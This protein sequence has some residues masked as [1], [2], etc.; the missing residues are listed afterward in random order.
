MHPALLLLKSC[1]HCFCAYK[2]FAY[3][4]KMYLYDKKIYIKQTEKIMKINRNAWN[5]S[6]IINAKEKKC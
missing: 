5:V 2:S 6:E 3:Q 4:S 1:F